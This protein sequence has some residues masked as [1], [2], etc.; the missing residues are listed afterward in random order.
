M[1]E[2]MKETQAIVAT[3]VPEQYKPTAREVKTHEIIGRPLY[4]T[5]NGNG[6]FLWT[7]KS[8][9]QIFKVT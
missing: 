6:H 3:L 8:K 7:G 2:V 5:C 4:I 1:E 9:V